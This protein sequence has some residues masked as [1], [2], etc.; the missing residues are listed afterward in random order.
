MVAFHIFSF[1]VF[2]VSEIC[3]HTGNG[4]IFLAAVQRGYS[5]ILLLLLAALR[6]FEK[7]HTLSMSPCWRTGEGSV[8]SRTSMLP[9]LA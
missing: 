5:V 3:P 2:A 8:V 9:P 1:L 6:L 7:A 4:K